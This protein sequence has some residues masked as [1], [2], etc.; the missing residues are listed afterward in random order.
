MLAQVKYYKYHA[1]G[2]DYLVIA[3]QDLGS[4]NQN[5]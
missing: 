5:I 3:P 4:V 1:L 2:N